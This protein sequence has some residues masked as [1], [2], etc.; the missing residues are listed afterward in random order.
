ME[1]SDIWGKVPVK[2]TS[3]YNIVID[4]VQ[5]SVNSNND[6]LSYHLNSTEKENE[7]EVVNR[8]IGKTQ[9]MHLLPALPDRSLIVKPKRNLSILP[10]TSFKF[11]V[12]LPVTFQLYAGVVKP[13]N[14]IFEHALANLSSTWFGE[15]HD[16]E[17]CYAVYS[18][19]D[20]EISPEKKGNNYVIC[21][22]EIANNSKEVLE[23][24]R[25][26]VRGIHLN[27]YTNGKLLISNKVK[28]NYLGLDN[29]SNIEFSRNATSTIPNLKQIAAARAPEN[30]TILKRSF[31]LIRHITQF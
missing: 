1:K 18:S 13:E 26:A 12:Y 7:E 6:I 14:K 25:L 2:K 29:L 21:P 10:S 22:I 4:K 31:Q 16:G 11:Y 3:T 15:P 28:I 5:L 23:V 19:F 8:V 24:K 20:T 17:L 30:K 27:I 9:E